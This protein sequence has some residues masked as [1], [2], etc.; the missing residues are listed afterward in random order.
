ML[1]RV[2]LSG[3]GHVTQRSLNAK[4]RKGGEKEGRPLGDGKLLKSKVL[5]NP[6]KEPLLWCQGTQLWEAR[7][8]KVQRNK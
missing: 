3:K 5:Q 4:E 6:R 1:V 7:N 2:Y 8:Q